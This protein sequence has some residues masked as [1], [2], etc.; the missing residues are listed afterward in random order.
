[1]KLNRAFSLFGGLPSGK[2]SA[3]DQPS[4]EELLE[5]YNNGQ[6]VSGE[7][8]SAPESEPKA[9]TREPQDAKEEPMPPE[10]AAFAG[11]K[12]LGAFGTLLHSRKIMV[13][14]L[15]IA[16]AAL[17]FCGFVE[18]PE[19]AD[20][21]IK[22]A[23][24]VLVGYDLVFKAFT[25]VSSFNFTG[26]A[27]PVII[28][29]IICLCAGG[30]AQA[31]AALIIYQLSLIVLG[32]ANARI[33]RLCRKG[34]ELLEDAH[35][36]GDIMELAEGM[37]CVADCVVREGSGSADMSFITG[38]R[39]AV[40]LLIGSEIPA[41]A[42]ITR[43]LM[44]VEVTR[45]VDSSIASVMAREL[46]NGAKS[47]TD[48][49][50]KALSI[51]KVLVITTLIVGLALMLILPTMFNVPIRESIL[52]AAAVIALATPG[53]LL[54][55]I[56]LTF[57]IGM[58]SARR[59]GILF[60]KASDVEKTARIKA[61]VFDKVGT[62]TG[63]D[64]VV[65]DI[66]TDKMDPQTFL[67]VAAYAEANSDDPIARAIVAAYGKPV[68]GTLVENY[69]GFGG[70]G[71]SVSV[72]GIEILLG[73]QGFLAE[74]GISLPRITGGELSVHMTVNGIYAGRITLS[75]NV[76]PS[77]GVTVNRLAQSGVERIT[78]ISPD[79]RERDL[80]IARELGID[81][82][83]AECPPSDRPRRIKEMKAR[84]DP[85]Y[86]MAYVSADIGARECFSAADVGIAVGGIEQPRLFELS[87]VCIMQSAPDN[88]AAA[89]QIAQGVGRYTKLELLFTLL[90]KLVIVM[91][92]AF[93]FAPLWLCLLLDMI[94]AL[95]VLFDSRSALRLGGNIGFSRF[96]L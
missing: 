7:D 73:N 39:T 72:N 63:R 86:T 95:G 68:S 46:L 4:F 26:G 65:S 60:S 78:M 50:A 27:I 43:G 59:L 85:Q 15:F 67:K 37:T 54:L 88:V 40:N 76:L 62:L 36:P 70:R 94:A 25:D 41:G 42:H 56:P 51:S 17:A 5:R 3:A 29:A 9:R 44:T 47:K 22:I 19:A 75:D 16:A 18:M 89:V 49:W 66:A 77:A 32:F 96:K 2:K 92:A 53:S 84:I 31:V 33:K 12:S 57:F 61:I 34:F 28:A 91:L 20:I 81:E 71:V 93:G 24:A 52:R 74:Q 64:Y 48:E 1:M 79:N 45:S 69:V 35:A 90:Y 83:I 87:N 13:L 30:S 23:A 38:D 82:Y 55:A 58:T 6:L 11:R 14:R 21:L 80:A 8:T 10:E